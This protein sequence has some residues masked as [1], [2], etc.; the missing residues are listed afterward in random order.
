MIAG[1]LAAVA[2]ALFAAAPAFAHSDQGAMTA[3]ARPAAQPLAVTARARVVFTNDGHA[4]NEAAVTVTGTGPGGAQVGPAPLTRV[5][6]GEYEAV[7][8]VPA[9]GE[10]SFQ[11]ASTTPTAN[12]TAATT[13]PS[14]EAAT[15]PRLGSAKRATRN[16]GDDSSGLNAS[17]FAIGGG[18]VVVAALVGGTLVIRRRR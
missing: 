18:A 8:P 1:S 10:W 14:P 17:V 4:A 5:D 3:E 16:D 15:P 11:L 6:E 12:A 13:V 9:A 7:V 2:V